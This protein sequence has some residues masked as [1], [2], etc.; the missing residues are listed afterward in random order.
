MV[1]IDDTLNPVHG[2]GETCRQRSRPLPEP[3]SG[4]KVSTITRRS[5]VRHT[6]PPWDRD[7]VS[8][9]TT[10]TIPDRRD[11][12]G[13]PLPSPVTPRDSVR[14]RDRGEGEGSTGRGRHCWNR[15]GQIPRPSFTPPVGRRRG[16]DGTRSVVRER[17]SHRV[18]SPAVVVPGGEQVTGGLDDDEV[19]GVALVAGPVDGTPLTRPGPTH[20]HARTHSHL[21][22]PLGSRC[23]GVFT[24]LRTRGGETPWDPFRDRTRPGVKG[25]DS[26]PTPMGPLYG[27]LTPHSLDLR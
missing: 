1:T 14:R 23:L 22:T 24:F 8:S 2:T 11:L 10:G 9:R 7:H 15:D 21:Q 20:T 17:G 27:V 6:L 3:L 18:S 16:R 4:P 13:G 25:R 26:L 19:T 5:F 12:G